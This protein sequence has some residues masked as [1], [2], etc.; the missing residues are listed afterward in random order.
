MPGSPRHRLAV[1]IDKSAS[2]RNP[3]IA[4]ALSP[5]HALSRRFFLR[6]PRPERPLLAQSGLSRESC[7]LKLSRLV[8]RRIVME[9]N[10]GE[11]DEY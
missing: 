6:S 8:L 5:L 7:K 9:R 10:I 11:L 2:A 1:A 4:S 3:F